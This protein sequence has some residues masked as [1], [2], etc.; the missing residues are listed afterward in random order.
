MH[1]SES[2]EQIAVELE[3]LRSVYQIFGVHPY[4]FKRNIV[5]KGVTVLKE[6]DCYS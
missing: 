1:P 6:L 4:E 3:V 5:Y 2:F